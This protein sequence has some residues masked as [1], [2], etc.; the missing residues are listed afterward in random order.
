[1]R[2]RIEP[3]DREAHAPIA[4]SRAAPKNPIRR[5]TGIVLL[6]CAALFVYGLFAD[7]FTPYTAQ[8]TVQ[9]YVVRVAADVAGRISAVNVIDNQIVRTGEVLFEI[10]RERYAIAVETAEAQLAAAGQAVG[11]STA[12][13]ASAEAKLAEAEAK[14]TNIQ[15]QTARIFEMVKKGI[16]AKA[17]SDQ[18]T[19]SLDAAIADVD[20]AKAD[21]EEARQNMGPQGADNPQIRQA[22]AA[23]RKAR[24][25]LTDTIVL[26]PSD[27]VITNLQLATGQYVAVGQAV[28][29]F[30]DAEVI[31]IDAQFRE[32][33]LEHVAAGNAADVVLDIRPGRVYPATVESVGWGV[34]SK[35][36]DPTTGLPVIRNDTGWIRDAQRFAVR[37]QFAPDEQPKGIRLGSQAN[38]VIYTGRAPV[39]DAIGRLWIVLVSYLSY[40]S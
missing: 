36:I 33:S 30:I 16:Y 31:W 24:R 38:V 15:E 5:L 13:L 11:A 18:A 6:L 35:D 1:M 27:G 2:R 22:Q 25:D 9:A 28:L 26:A 8:A 29:T 17:R 32:N 39:T 3:E 7:R 21:V 20:R 12:A 34:D 14:L 19:A 4:T 40:L 10:D 23:L 37:V